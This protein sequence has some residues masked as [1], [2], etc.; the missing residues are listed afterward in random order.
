MKKQ[1]I[2][3]ILSL[4]IFSSSQLFAQEKVQWHTLEEVEELMKKE[5][6][7]IIIDVYTDWCHWC[8]KMDKTTFNHPEIAKYINKNF[9]AVKINAESKKSITFNNKTYLTKGR[10][11]D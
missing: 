10:Y 5:P 3:S 4:F 8:K 6:R 9:Y 11:N 1:L 7:K 2:L